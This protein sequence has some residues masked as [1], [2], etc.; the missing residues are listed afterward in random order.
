MTAQGA[1]FAAGLILAAIVG[2][3]TSA[4]QGGATGRQ[5]WTV[6]SSTTACLG[7]FQSDDDA[8]S[9]RA[10]RAYFGTTEPVLYLST[11]LD[12]TSGSAAIV[13][14]TLRLAGESQP[15]GE[16]TMLVRADQT[17]SARARIVGQALTRLAM[18]QGPARLEFL[19]DDKVIGVRDT[20]AFAHGVMMLDECFAELGEDLMAAQPPGRDTRPGPYA[21][22]P[23]N[24]PGTWVTTSDYP[25]EALRAEQEGRAAS[26]LSV[27]RYGFVTACEIF[28][29]S[30]SPLLDEATCRNMASRARFYP[31]RD[32]NGEAAEGIFTQSVRWSIPE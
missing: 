17:A 23:R 31:A 20:S 25:A 5:G 19:N 15:L 3:A 9:L 27:N 29:S 4:Q 24:Y 2:S 1:K 13:P 16:G 10:E 22:V 26:R 12:W 18:L 6:S 8:L 14:F 21:P 11:I 30:G 7:T 32:T 28:E